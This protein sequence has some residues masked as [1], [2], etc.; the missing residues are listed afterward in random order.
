[1]MNSCKHEFIESE[2][3][4]HYDCLILFLSIKHECMLSCMH[5]PMR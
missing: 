2:T 4:W 1:M 3:A 5:D